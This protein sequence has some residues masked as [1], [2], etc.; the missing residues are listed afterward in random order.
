MSL[1]FWRYYVYN[2]IKLSMGSKTTQIPKFLEGSIFSSFGLNR[3]PVLS[4][5]PFPVATH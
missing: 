1:K 3:H 2:N 5:V 4:W